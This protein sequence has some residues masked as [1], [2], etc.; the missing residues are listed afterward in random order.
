VPVVRG[1]SDPHIHVQSDLNADAAARNKIASMFGLVSDLP[2]VVTTGCEMRVPRAMTSALPARVTCLACRDHAH[3]QHLRSAEQLE[4]L[5]RM[6]GMNVSS[7]QTQQAADWH[8]DLAAKFA[9]IGT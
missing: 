5:G 9:R 3:R 4:R 8:R 2:S 1:E 6:P 7:A